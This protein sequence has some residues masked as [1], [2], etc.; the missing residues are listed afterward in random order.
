MD[1]VKLIEVFKTMVRKSH[2]D[3]KTAHDCIFDEKSSTETALSYLNKAISEHCCCESLYYSKF[4]ELARY[5]YEEYSHQFE[6]FSNELLR[7][8]RTNHSHQWTDIEFERLN[9]LFENSA[10]AFEN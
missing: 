1:N 4:D 10:F 2:L 7:N 5:E 6:T 3:A 9:E 8:V